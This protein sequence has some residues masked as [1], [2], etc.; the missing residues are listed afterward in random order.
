MVAMSTPAWSRCIAGRTTRGDTRLAAR[1]GHRSTPPA[2]PHR[3]RRAARRPAPRPRR[4]RISSRK[5]TAHDEAQGHR[6]VLRGP[7]RVEWQP[8]LRFT[9]DVRAG[10]HVGPAVRTTSPAAAAACRSRTASCSPGTPPVG[11]SAHQFLSRPASLRSAPRSLASILDFPL[12][13][14][15]RHR[16]RHVDRRNPAPPRIEST[17]PAKSTTC[18]GAPA[19]GRGGYTSCM[20]GGDAARCS[21]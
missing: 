14:R 9:L 19:A 3:A 20:C 16:D 2:S 15:H 13:G 10:E 12:D 18:T 4:V 5:D 8:G 6:S 17:A 21:R 11:E 1:L 7:Q